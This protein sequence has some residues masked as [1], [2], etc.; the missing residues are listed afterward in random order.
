MFSFLAD[1]S[2][3]NLSVQ[4]L[5]TRWNEVLS[6][7]NDTLTDHILESLYKMQVEK[8]ELKILVAILRSTDDIRR[9]GI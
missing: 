4:A 8:K 5:Y 7:V 3:S 9:P 1:L 6:A 2:K